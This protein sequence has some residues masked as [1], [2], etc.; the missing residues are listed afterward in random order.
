MLRVL[1][2]NW[3]NHKVGHEASQDS[4]LLFG[5]HTGRENVTVRPCHIFVCN[6]NAR[7]GGDAHVLIPK[8][9]HNQN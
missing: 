2:V 1:V 4:L 9:T 7:N 6:E 8:Q 5:V 3:P